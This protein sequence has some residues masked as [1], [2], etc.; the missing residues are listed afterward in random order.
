MTALAAI[1][2]STVFD[3]NDRDGWSSA[4]LG[5]VWARV[6][7]TKHGW[8]ASMMKHDF[9]EAIP[10]GERYADRQEA[11]SACEDAYLRYTILSRRK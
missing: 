1:Q 3:W 7:E 6:W 8:C 11:K 5:G 4:G 10:I 9:C 2:E